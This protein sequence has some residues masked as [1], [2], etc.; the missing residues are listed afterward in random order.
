MGELNM[1]RQLGLKPN[2]SEIGKRYG[3]DR[4]TVSRYW[5]EGGDVD[6]GRCNRASGFDAHG[7]LIAEKAAMPGATKKAVYEYLLHRCG[8]R[9]IPG[10][11]AFTRYCRRHDV[12]FGAGGRAE[13]HPRFE[14]PPGRQLQFDWKEDLRMVS[15]RGETF[16]FNVFSATLGC[17]RMHKFVYSKTRTRDDLLSCWLATISFFGACPRNG[18]P[19]TCPP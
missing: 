11:N 17:S 6:D 15:R 7:D 13:P 3:I 2:F 4:H 5:R 16:E 14:T 12:A 8:G 18:S 9:P 19:T 1:Y 10:Y